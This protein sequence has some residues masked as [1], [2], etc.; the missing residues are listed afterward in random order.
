MGKRRF[1][2]PE[3]SGPSFGLHSAI[4]AGELDL[5]GESADSAE[6]KVKWFLDRWSRTNPGAVVRI[7]TGKGT[8]SAGDAVLLP[9]VRDLLNGPGA[10]FVDEWT[11]DTSGGA[12]LVRV[13]S[14]AR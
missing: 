14:N 13:K 10:R 6:Q 5:H 4:V 1:T 2:E 3:P 8:R 11:N 9:L 12:V 7:I